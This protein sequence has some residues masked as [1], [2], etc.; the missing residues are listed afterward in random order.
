MANREAVIVSAVRSTVGRA[1]RGVL[2]NV[3]PEDLGV[4]VI[5]E[6]MA[7]TPQV[8]P[9]M[10]D[11]V[12][13]GNAMPEGSQGMN[14]GRV[15]AYMAGLPN[16]V[17]GI[18]VN[19]FCSSGLQTIAY[20][21]M[22]VMSGMSDII[23]AGG[24]E[25][26]SSVPMGGFNFTANLTAVREY[27]EIYT[28]MGL[29]A[30]LVAE[31]YNVSR[32]TQDAFAYNSH[33]KAVAAWKEGKFDAEVVKVPYVDAKGNVKTLDQDESMRAETTIESLSKLRP[34]FRQGGSVTAGN[35]SPTN[36]GAS[37]VMVMGLDK[38]KELGLTPMAYV[39]DFQVAGTP[40]EVMG[41]G[42][43][44]AIPKLWEHSGIGKDKV[45]L[46]EVNEAF[47]AQAHYCCF[48][49]LDLDPAKVNV[50]GGAIALGHPLGCTG[51]KLTTSLLYEMKRRNEKYGV[52]SMCIGGGMGAAGLFE[53]YQ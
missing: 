36:D 20:A 18:T 19:R 30:E 51:A 41:I 17:P 48:D 15:V 35:S 45:G 22:E 24:V 25:S 42:P 39:R 32:E 5:K 9:E 44:V 43:A 16:S 46:Y 50:N 37:V 26:M 49:A 6:L 38:A 2:A 1:K 4:L 7:R 47:A 29:T 40:P 11:D 34:V 21:A 14:F 52:V 28:P 27:V 12:V 33:M 31:R 8:K 10:I 53:L 23:I 13:I 3:R